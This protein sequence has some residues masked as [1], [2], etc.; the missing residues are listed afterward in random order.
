MA[1][2]WL[3]GL[4]VPWAATDVRK[5]PLKRLAPGS[6][7]V[8]PVRNFAAFFGRC[9]GLPVALATRPVLRGQAAQRAGLASGVC[10]L[11]FFSCC[12]LEGFQ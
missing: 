5:P 4:L 2:L 11:P 9:P 1:S 7:P 6:V 3:D 8:P 10:T 12:L